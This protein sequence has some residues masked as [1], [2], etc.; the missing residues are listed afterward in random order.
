MKSVR[1][2]TLTPREREI[3][4]LI[5]EGNSLAEIAQ[6]LSRSL[7][8]IESHRLAIGKKLDASNRVELTHIAIAEGLVNVQTD[9]HG[10]TRRTDTAGLAATEL[11]W[12]ERI[13]TACADAKGATFIKRFCDAASQLPGITM[14]AI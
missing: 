10:N 12:L 5:A 6:K 13:N 2:D 11:A 7:K 1:I 8:T 4:T 3:L 14:A 9:H